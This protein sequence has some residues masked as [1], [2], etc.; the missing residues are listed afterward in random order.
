M[1]YHSRVS[2]PA[3]RTPYRIFIVSLTLAVLFLTFVIIAI[4]VVP[5]TAL[6]WVVP[7]SGGVLSARVHATVELP[8]SPPAERLGRRI[9]AFDRPADS[10]ATF[11]SHTAEAAVL[12]DL[13]SGAHLYRN[14]ACRSWP[15]ASLT[16]LVTMY[17]V[18]DRLAS[19]EIREDERVVPH[20]RAH[21][22][23]MPAGSSLLYL[24]PEQEVS[25]HE[26]LSGLA[27][28]SGNDA[29]YAVA[30]EMA[31]GPEDF[32]VDMNEAVAETGIGGLQ[33]S[34]PSGISSENIITAAG[35]GDFLVHY[36]RRFPEAVGRYHAA[37]EFEFSPVYGDG[38]ER[39]PTSVGHENRNRLVG[40]Y[41]GADGLKT[42]YI[43]S[44]G[45]NMAATAERDG[46][47]LVAVVLGV[48]GENHLVGGIRRAR[49]AADLLDYGFEQFEAGSIRSSHSSLELRVA[50][51]RQDAVPLEFAEIRLLRPSQNNGDSAISGAID[52]R[53]HVPD[54]I[55][56]PVAAGD[57]VGFVSVLHRGQ[58]VA[59]QPVRASESAGRGF[60]PVHLFSYIKAVAGGIP[61]AAE[62]QTV[63]LENN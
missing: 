57:I 23:E 11:P 20:E 7:E 29:A 4:A 37:E 56:A 42:G 15:A 18:L 49:E 45:Y 2:R 12:I 63:S 60:T 35:F 48:K 28:A 19:G 5:A 44:S 52:S 47:R 31:A 21:W 34:E 53:L 55:R 30:Y 54:A 32:A 50:G 9:A 24:A 51:G 27:I 1:S 62:N 14:N 40:E 33:F 26:L 36:L 38:A 39:W 3:R 10:P 43:R 41:E 46:R 13:D 6:A 25:W 17:V 16:K 59:W 22:R 8:E 58:R 61:S